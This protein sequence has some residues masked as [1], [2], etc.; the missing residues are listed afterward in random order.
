MRKIFSYKKG[1]RNKTSF[2]ST[3]IKRKNIKKS[4]S[5]K[6]EVVYSKEELEIEKALNIYSMYPCLHYDI[7][8]YIPVIKRKVIGQ[9]KAVESLVYVTYF[10][11]YVNFLE[12]YM[13]KYIERK[14]IFLIAPTGCGKS[15][16]LRALEKA[17]DVP[18]YRANITATTSAGY[19]GD[20]VESMLLGLIEKAKGNIALAEKGVLL[21]DEIDKKITSTTSDRDVSGKAVQQELLKL[22]DK[23]T[24][25]LPIVRREADEV[26]TRNI[27]FNT[28]GLTII[29]AGA[30]VGLDEIRKKRLGSKKIGFKAELEEKDSLEYT[31]KDL[32]QYGFIPELVGR[33]KV[34][35]EFEPYT[36]DKLI[37]IIYFSDESCMQNHVT[38]LESLNVSKI[39]IDAYLWDKI[40][41]EVINNNEEV[42]IRGLN[43]I[44]EELFRPIIFEAF[45]HVGIGAGSCEI[46]ED[47][48][49]V[50]KYECSDKVY[51]GQGIH[52]KESKDFEL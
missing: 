28:G 27:E 46:K 29:L 16:M 48:S 38:I 22:F 15:T 8:S 39:M 1:S 44:I 5:E 12:E 10:N 24:V 3:I 26:F 23:G 35:E 18:V 52:L 6:E 51:E 21:I 20:K 41:E 25:N 4:K 33:I 36:S 2:L 30:C 37:D 17:F 49:Y 32:I 45:Q 42:G 7:K 43:N 19:I 13:G 34:I 31:Y 47:G 9:D 11:Q 50:L 14:S 40:A